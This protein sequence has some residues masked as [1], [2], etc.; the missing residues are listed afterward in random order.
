[1]NYPWHSKA[2]RIFAGVIAVQW[3]VAV[4]LGIHFSTLTLALALATLAALPALILIL[5]APHSFVSRHTV[6]IATQLLTALHIHLTMGLTE[7]HFEI[8]TVMAFLSIYRDWKIILTAVGV[9]ALHHI[10]FFFIQLSGAPVFV[11]ESGHLLFSMLMLHAFFAIAEGAVLM[12]IA[13]GTEQESKDN[14]LLSDA[15]QA[16]CTNG[17]IAANKNITGTSVAIN[18]FNKLL[19]ALRELVNTIQTS[20][21]SSA[22]LSEQLLS[23]SSQTLK[24]LQGNAV[25]VS[26][27]SSSLT[28][29]SSANTEVAENVVGINHLSGEVKNETTSTKALI[30]ENTHEAESLKNDIE[31]A[32][33]SIKSLAEMVQSIQSSMTSIKNISDQTNL[34]A[35]NA[36]IESARAGE[37]G[38]GFSVVADEVRALAL[39]TNHNAE[40]ITQITELLSG[41][42]KT[43]V[44]SM[45][46][47]AEQFAHS[48]HNTQVVNE[49]VSN[50]DQLMNDLNQRIATVAAATEEQS[51]MSNTI[52][53]S[54][55]EL[56]SSTE[57]QVQAINANQ[58]QLNDLTAQ[59][60]L[61]NQQ[62]TRFET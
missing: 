8:F 39:K 20:G 24:G 43:A 48:L 34:L 47:C 60:T 26:Q 30:T 19:S 37:F 33:N 42:A 59:I 5:K 45:S 11:F 53:K 1:M 38:R 15:V 12:H 7:M 2:N 17:K 9:V 18:E 35:L 4:G 55:Q 57:N 21:S 22:E 61:L 58:Y 49:R 23:T 62:L 28:Q 36:A 25:N 29:I 56:H 3:A 10:S 31:N 41:Q 46:T 16:V 54:A 52:A 40:E 14:L 6:A 51:S 44:T 50:I 27:I 13:H 32:V